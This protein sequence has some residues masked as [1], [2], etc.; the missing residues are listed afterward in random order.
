M[1][2]NASNDS[3]LDQTYGKGRVRITLKATV[4]ISQEPRRFVEVTTVTYWDPRNTQ[5]LNRSI[6]YTVEERMAW[7][8]GFDRLSVTACPKTYIAKLDWMCHGK[9][10]DVEPLLV[11]PIVMQEKAAKAKY[12]EEF[13]RRRQ[14]QAM[15]ARQEQARREQQARN[16][17]RI[18]AGVFERGMSLFLVVRGVKLDRDGKYKRADQVKPSTLSKN[19]FAPPRQSLPSNERSIT[20]TPGIK[21]GGPNIKYVKKRGVE[22]KQSA[23]VAERR[24]SSFA[25][26][27]APKKKM[28]RPPK[29]PPKPRKT[30]EEKDGDYNDK[31]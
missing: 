2:V 13:V 10:S 12:G 15:Y 5:S 19:S 17:G 27:T 22:E 3:L 26:D 25:T 31:A 7:K 9:N 18:R 28:G 1:Q 24:K 8:A 11:H 6:M 4:C 20:V 14:W 29:Q 23:A 30:Q 21:T 16:Q